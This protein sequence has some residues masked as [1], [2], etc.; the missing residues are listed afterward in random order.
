MDTDLTHVPVVEKPPGTYGTTPIGPLPPKPRAAVAP[1]PSSS[2]ASKI[3]LL[4]EVQQL[5]IDSLNQVATDGLARLGP[6][7]ISGRTGV[8]A[9]QYGELYEFEL[10]THGRCLLRHND[11]L[12]VAELTNVVDYITQVEKA[13]LRPQHALVPH[14]IIHEVLVDVGHNPA[15]DKLATCL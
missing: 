7:E 9:H 3:S 8:V 1:V 13:A 6:W 4:L 15:T 11:G 2:S 14:A 5:L 12:D 10:T